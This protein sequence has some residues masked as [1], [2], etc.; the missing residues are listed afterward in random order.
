MLTEAEDALENNFL[1]FLFFSRRRNTVE[2][3]ENNGINQIQMIYI[4]QIS[5]IA[6]L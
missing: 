6:R 3:K 2:D 1:K 4:P 5:I